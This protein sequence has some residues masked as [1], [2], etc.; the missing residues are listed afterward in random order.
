MTAVRNILFIMCDQLRWDHL[1]C[2]GHPR[3]HTPNIDALAARGVRFDRAY[4]QSPVCGASRMS[5]YTGRYVHS[6]RRQLELRAAEGR[7]DDDRRSSAAARRALGARRQDAHARRH[8]RHG[9]P[10]HRSQFDDRRAHLRMRLRPLR[11]RRRHPPLL[12]PRSASSL[13][14]LPAR[15]GLR[16][17]EP[18]GG[19]GERRRGRRRRAALGLVP[20]E[21]RRGPRAFPTSIPRRP[22]SRGARWISSARRASSRGACTCPTSSRTGPTSCRS[23]TLRCTRRPM[24]CPSCATS[25]R[26]PTRIPSTAR[27]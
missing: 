5:F 27:S 24:R 6:A 3:L 25:A 19:V 7:R 10:R 9:A 22:T 4:V 17:R 12:G 8:D 18:V 20:E 13:Q 14:R 21:L 15:A 16:G 1:S 26:G 2:Y 23:P 11:A